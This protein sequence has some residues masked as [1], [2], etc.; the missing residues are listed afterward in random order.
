MSDIISEE[1]KQNMSSSDST[2]GRDIKTPYDNEFYDM[3]NG[4]DC[5]S[6]TNTRWLNKRIYQLEKLPKLS[7][8]QLKELQNAYS[9]LGKIPGGK[10]KPKVC[11]DF[12]NNGT[13]S[14]GEIVTTNGP[15]CVG[16]RYHPAPEEAEYLRKNNK[17]KNGNVVYGKMKCVPRRKSVRLESHQINVPESQK[18]LVKGKTSSGFLDSELNTHDYFKWPEN[19]VK[20]FY[21]K[22]NPK[23]LRKH[24]VEK[25]T[26]RWNKFKP[27]LV[28]DE[29]RRKYGKTPDLN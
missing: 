6:G 27:H 1:F 28:V 4:L 13:C 29:C 12:V 21:E 11:W 8:D 26:A 9:Q 25:I 10:K 22:V 24:G 3:M 23:Y 20:E 14:H 2:D 5:I 15:I 16:K 19:V 17:W 18:K 7:Q